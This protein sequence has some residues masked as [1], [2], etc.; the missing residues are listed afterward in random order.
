MRTVV[1]LRILVTFCVVAMSMFMAGTVE[2][3]SYDHSILFGGGLADLTPLATDANNNVYVAQRGNPNHPG[4]CNVIDEDGR[5]LR[6][7]TVDMPVAWWPTG[8]IDVGQDGT[9]CLGI[10][11]A[12]GKGRVQLYDK[13]GAIINTIHLDD[14]GGCSDVA[15]DAAGDVWVTNQDLGNFTLRKFDRITGDV[16][17]EY[18]KIPGV[19]DRHEWYYPQGVTVDDVGRI[20]VADHSRVVR[21]HPGDYVGTAET[22]AGTPQL[23][24]DDDA[25]F[26]G[27][28]TGVDVDA[29]GNVY[30]A[31]P[32]NN[33][34]K[35][36]RPNGDFLQEIT[37]PSL[38]SPTEVAVDSLG[39]VYVSESAA[40]PQLHKFSPIPEPATMSLLGIVCVLALRRNRV[41][42][43]LPK[44]K[45]FR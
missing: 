31:C 9:I 24:G 19:S 18:V 43:R 21:F 38:N 36:F 33:A 3:V 20:L 22:F 35:V 25:L 6:T 37:H 2:A 1:S 13:S 4:V 26:R 39:N 44:K 45:A 12:F 42:P 30:V 23:T 17:Q 10:S 5:V 41:L 32:A 34:I 8:G 16:V 7:I 28:I 14:Y 27:Q 40:D 11:T 15:L 29:A